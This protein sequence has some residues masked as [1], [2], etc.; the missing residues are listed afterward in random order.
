M[1]KIMHRIIIKVIIVAYSIRITLSSDSRKGFYVN[2][3][4]HSLCNDFRLIEG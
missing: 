3:G 1:D 2:R 4:L